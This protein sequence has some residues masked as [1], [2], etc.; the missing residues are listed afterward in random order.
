MFFALLQKTNLKDYLGNI[1]IFAGLISSLAH[2]M[3]HRT[4]KDCIKSTNG[5]IQNRWSKQCLA[6][7]EEIN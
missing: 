6:F 3:N 2:D 1:E 7:E 4:L 5:I